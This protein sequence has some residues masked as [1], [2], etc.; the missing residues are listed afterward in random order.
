MAEFER[1]SHFFEQVLQVGCWHSLVKLSKILGVIDSLW[2]KIVKICSK[3]IIF[4]RKVTVEGL[5]EEDQIYQAIM[6]NEWL[7]VLQQFCEEMP[8]TQRIFIL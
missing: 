3:G 4:F 1:D 8:H 2:E 7:S 5:V 6:Y